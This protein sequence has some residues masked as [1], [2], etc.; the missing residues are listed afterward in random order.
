MINKNPKLKMYIRFDGLGNPIPST[1]VLRTTAPKDGKYIRIQPEGLCC[2]GSKDSLIIF[3]NNSSLADITSIVSA[4]NSINWTGTLTKNDMIAFVIPFGYNET[5]TTTFTTPTGDIDVLATVS[6]GSS[7][8][9][10][11]PNFITSGTV[12]PTS[13]IVTISK[14]NVQYLVTIIND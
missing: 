4:D 1:L 5:I 7:T 2:D 8:I 14:P 13:S 9:T 10:A 6:Q 11:T 3:Y 12:T